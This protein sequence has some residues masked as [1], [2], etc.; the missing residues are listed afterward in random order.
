MMLNANVFIRI[1]FLDVAVA[2]SQGGWTNDPKA[3]GT[4]D[5]N[6]AVGC[7]YWV[8]DVQSTDTG[9]L[10]YH[11]QPTGFLGKAPKFF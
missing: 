2:A 9:L 8:K 4:K 5:P 3:T 7:D 1:P 10:Q 11:P 6:A